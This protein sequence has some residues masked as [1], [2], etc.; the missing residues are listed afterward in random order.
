MTTRSTDAVCGFATS[1]GHRRTRNEDAVLPGPG[2]FVVADGM[3]GHDAGDI[4]SRLVVDTFTAWPADELADAASITITVDAANRAI[5]D[6]ALHHGTLGMGSTVVG[7]VL[8]DT[9]AGRAPIVFHA[10]DSR[11]YR[12]VR[13]ELRLLTRDHSHVQELIDA[14]QLTTE[15]AVH[16]PLRNVV[17][18]ALGA[19]PTVEVDIAVLDATPSRFLL[20]TDGLTAE[21]RPRTIGRVLAGIADPQVAADRL[22]ALALD[23]PA[24]DN[25][26]A[27]IVDLDPSPTVGHQFA[28][29]PTTA[30]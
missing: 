23:G 6:H 26:T 15:Q 8:G 13:G 28:A 16:H 12:L 27:L 24:T 7:L 17:T 20:C 19:D 18:R 3:G 30:P 1:A 9:P 4:A 10:G 29:E 11:C 5:R 2:W 14:N 22:I 25:L 21:L